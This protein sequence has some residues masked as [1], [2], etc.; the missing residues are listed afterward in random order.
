LFP[1]DYLIDV[2][3]LIQLWTA[4]GF[5]LGTISSNS[6]TITAKQQ[7]GRACFNDFVPLVFH[8]VEEESDHHQYCG[9]VRNNMNND[10]YRMNKL[11]HKLARVVT[12]GGENITVSSM[13]DRVQGRTLRV[14]FNFALDLSCEI[15]DSVFETAKKLRTILLPY[16]TNNPRLPHEVKMTT[17]TCDKIFN[18]FKCSLRALDLHDLGIKTVPSSIEEVK[19]LR[20]LDL[21]HNNMEKLPSCITN[22]VHLQTLKLSQCH[23]LKELPKDIEDLSSLNHLD[24]EGCL[25]LTHLPSGINK[26]TSLQTLSLFVANKKQVMGGLRSLM[27]LNNLK[28]H[29]EI[30]HLEQV[31]FSPSKEA[32][33]YEILKNKKLQFLTLRWDHDEEDEVE[34]EVDKDKK[35]LECLQPHPNLKV[36]LVVGYNGHTLS[37][38][39]TSLQNLVKFT[40]NDCPKCQFLPTMDKLQHLKVLQLRRLD[41]L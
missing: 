25:D 39:L 9:V 6:D 14:S 16:N 20:F 5:L 37:N 23:V 26:L 33:E 32:A 19:Y 17:S 11:M 2:E 29:L 22:L 41:S 12:A 18:T 4:E 28:G 13:V 7:F 36:L 15:P 10:L 35:S 3:R 21:S 24:I 1:E 27:D 40:L 8:Q 38:W 34:S 31:K 30:S